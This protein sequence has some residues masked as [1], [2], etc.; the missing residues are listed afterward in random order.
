VARIHSAGFDQ[1]DL[2]AKHILVRSTGDGPRFCFLDWQRSRPRRTVSWQR[3]LQDLAALDASVAETLAS[4]RLRLT[5]LAAYLGERRGLSPPCARRGLSPPCARRGLSP[6]CARRGQAPPLAI[7]RFSERLFSRRKLRELRQPPLP[8]GAQ[9]LLWLQDDDRLCVACDFYGEVGSRLPSWLPQQ[10]KPNPAGLCVEHRLI[11]L[12]SGR[13]AHLVQRWSRAGGWLGQSKFPAPEMEQA[14][15]IFRL[16]RFGVAGPRLL[17][18]GHRRL[19]AWQQFSFLLTERPDGPALA[20]VLRTGSADE[21]EVLLEQFEALMRRV[22]DA[23]YA[24][25]QGVELQQ[26]WVV[27]DGGLALASVEALTR[28]RERAVA[29]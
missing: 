12:G 4:D 21:R 23:G 20:S 8:D 11:L 3:R 27:R 25:S 13:T 22:D 19:G 24:F 28:K 17:A 14:A 6:P 9:Q 15:T 18:M 10:P 29:R 26:A 5:F 1:P 16:Q 7:R 2:Y